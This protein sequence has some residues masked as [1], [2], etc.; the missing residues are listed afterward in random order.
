VQFHT[1][2]DQA[3]LDGWYREWPYVLDQAGVPEAEIRALDARHLPAQAALATA[4][5]GA[6]AAVVRGAA[7]PSGQ[8]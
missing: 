3:S 8:R 6:F 2:V 5:F 7:L 4:I 1:E